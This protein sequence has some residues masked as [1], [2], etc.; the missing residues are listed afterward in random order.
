MCDISRF[1]HDIAKR[2]DETGYNVIAGCLT[3]KGETTLT[4]V[5]SSRL[6]TVSLDV[7]DHESIKQAYLFVRNALPDE[8]GMIQ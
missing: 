3:E 5:C 4:K 8:Q 6:A 2:L 7:S 1:G